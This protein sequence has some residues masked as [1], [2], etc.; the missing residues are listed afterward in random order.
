VKTYVGKTAVITGAASGT[1]KALAGRCAREGMNVVLA[2]IED[3]AI[4]STQ[5]ELEAMASWLKYHTSNIMNILR[6]L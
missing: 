4:I 5:A 1:G 3:P 2:D 6:S